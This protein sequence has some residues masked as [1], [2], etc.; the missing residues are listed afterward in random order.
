V[1]AQQAQDWIPPPPPLF[2][3]LPKDWFYPFL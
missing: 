3:P 1:T 2:P